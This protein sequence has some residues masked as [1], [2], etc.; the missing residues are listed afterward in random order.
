LVHQED[1][2][3]KLKYGRCQTLPVS[4]I[5]CKSR[6]HCS[7]TQLDC[8]DLVNVLIFIFLQLLL[9]RAWIYV[10][11]W[12]SHLKGRCWVQIWP[13]TRKTKL[14]NVVFAEHE[15]LHKCKEPSDGS[16]RLVIP[17]LLSLGKFC[18]MSMEEDS[19]FFPFFIINCV[20]WYDQDFSQKQ[21]SP[22]CWTN[23]EAVA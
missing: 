12:Y 9:F 1:E 21:N 13:E 18:F 20:I 19:N 2:L 6:W 17:Y 4:T 8:F 3:N 5:R 14:N 11:H 16:A 15:K 7:T 10:A 23:L 22:K